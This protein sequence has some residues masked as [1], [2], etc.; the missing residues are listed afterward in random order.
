MNISDTLKR[1]RKQ[2]RKTK[3]QKSHTKSKLRTILRLEALFADYSGNSSQ[4]N[5]TVESISV[6]SK[7]TSHSVCKMSSLFRTF[8]DRLC[9]VIYGRSLIV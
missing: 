6:G 2:L 9:D 5:I 3:K 8:A 7:I 4:A 1:L